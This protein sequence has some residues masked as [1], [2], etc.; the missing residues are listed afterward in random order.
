MGQGNLGGATVY[1]I[2]HGGKMGSEPE[3]PGGGLGYMH[4]LKKTKQLGTC[5]CHD[6]RESRICHNEL[7][8][9][10]KPPQEPN[11]PPLAQQAERSTQA[12][13][14]RARRHTAVRCETVALQL[15]LI[16]I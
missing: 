5:T 10:E 16:H 1:I 6:V 11:E 9:R 4:I 12:T 8:M 13:G 7:S 2:E 14:Q 15:S 3:E